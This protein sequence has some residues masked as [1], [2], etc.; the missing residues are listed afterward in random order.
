MANRDFG[1]MPTVRFNRS[2]FPMPHGVKTSMSVGTLYPIHCQ[3]VLPGDTFKSEVDVVARV[4]S[5][6]LKPVADNIFMDVFHFFVPGRL[7]YDDFTNVFGSPTPSSYTTN[8]LA[9]IPVTTTSTTISPKTVWDYLGVPPGLTPPGLS[10]LPVR[11]FALIY[12]QWFR[13]ENVVDEVYVQHGALQSSELPNNSPWSAT[14]YSGQLPKVGKKKDYFTSCLRSPQRGE[15]VKLPLGTMAWVKTS[16]SSLSPT[17]GQPMRFVN[18][19]GTI[20]PTGT[21]PSYLYSSGTAESL[22]VDDAG[23]SPSGT[24]KSIIPNNL[25]ADLSSATAANVNDIRFAFQLQKMLERDALYGSRYNEYLLGHYGVSSADSRLQFTEYLGGGR[26]PIQIQQVAQTS[27]ASSDSPLANVA[28]YSLTNGKSRFVKGFTEHGF[29]ITCA[30]LRQLHTYQQGVPKM[31]MRKSRNDFYDPLFAS[32]GEQPVYRSELF[33]NSSDANL[34]SDVFGYNEAWADYRY[35]A[36]RISGEARSSATNTLDIWHFADKYA[37]APTLSASFV[38]ETP[39]YVDRTLAVPSSSQDQFL[40]DF[41]FNT[42][43]IRVMPVYS[44]PGLID[45]H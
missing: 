4:T 6:F 45:H 12:N 15:S 1:L 24:T 40:T 35:I 33:V 23:Y 36:S 20:L 2:K 18:G 31:F 16:S 14:N 25:Y 27:E 19:D 41:W 28:G 32:L 30:C 8:E 34:R 3:E 43:A 39:S 22:F 42:E 17:T 37:S 11:A 5:A 29:V 13:N 44:V 26:F 38:E 7:V 9:S 21:Y 10:I